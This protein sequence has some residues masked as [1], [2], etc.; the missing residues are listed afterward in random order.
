MILFGINPILM[1]AAIVPAI[2][3]LYQVYKH[4]RLEKESNGLIVRLV[5][6][7]II[8]T[9]IAAALETVGSMVL[10]MF[11]QR[12]TTLYYLILTFVVVGIS[13]ELSKYVLLK[14]VTWNNPEF[15]CKFDGVI[16]AV[17]VGLGFALWENIKYVAAYGIATALVRA[18]TAVPGHACFGV[19]M[20]VFY[21]MAKMYANRGEE[22]KS[23]ICRRLAVEVPVLLHG[24]YDFIAMRESG[25][26]SLT[27]VVF[28]II[29]FVIAFRLVKK[30]SAE[31]TYI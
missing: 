3:L 14:K 7:G 28:V 21:A 31:D 11:F 22:G 17:A 13:E 23:R 30:T 12:A 6:M 26:I 8:S 15:N 19:F 5:V 25:V 20:G 29:M 27:F 18:V 10:G 1:V 24:T 16:Y 2:V 4:D 9:L